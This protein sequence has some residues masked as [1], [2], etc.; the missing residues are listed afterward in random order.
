[1][2]GG[3]VLYDTKDPHHI[4][5]L[6]EAIVDDPRTEDGVLTTQ[7]AALDRL[8]GRDF[9]TTLLRFVEQ[10]KQRP[11]RPAPDTAWDFWAQ[12]DQFERLEELRQF[13]PAL[14]KALP[15]QQTPSAERPAPS[16]Q[17]RR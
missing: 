14:F 11:P 16:A 2:D 12:F 6:V 15:E 13:R 5:R 3:G 8:H 10:V 4:A 9:A 17:R 1:M 7:D